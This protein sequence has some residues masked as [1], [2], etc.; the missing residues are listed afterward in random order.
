MEMFQ[1]FS[2]GLCFF[3]G[4][5]GNDTKKTQTYGTVHAFRSAVGTFNMPTS[6]H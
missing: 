4:T 6:Y 3:V 2:V 5:Y 1:F